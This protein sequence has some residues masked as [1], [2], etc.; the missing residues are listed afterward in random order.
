MSLGFVGVTWALGIHIEI[1]QIGS[2]EIEDSSAYD[3]GER[4]Q[5]SSKNGN[6]ALVPFTS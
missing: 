6:R 2:R 3:H 5:C 1:E 4:I